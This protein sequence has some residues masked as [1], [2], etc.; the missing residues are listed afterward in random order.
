M[1][2]ESTIGTVCVNVH[3]PGVS[4]DYSIIS[5]ASGYTATSSVF[6]TS[7]NTTNFTGYQYHP[8]VGTYLYK[9]GRV[10]G[11]AFCQVTDYQVTSNGFT[12]IVK[13]KLISGYSQGGDSG[14]PYRNGTSFCGVHH[15]SGT[16]NGITYVY[17]TPY[18]TINGAGFSI[19]TN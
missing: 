10:S 9:Y 8:A 2:C 16:I 11:Q 15:G 7:G 4:G 12:N 3:S 14:R 19:K 13:A 17:F 6:T 5:A 1:R 18:E